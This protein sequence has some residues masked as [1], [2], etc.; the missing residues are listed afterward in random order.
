MAPDGSGGAARP[1]RRS[2]AA[3]QIPVDR[4]GVALSLLAA[5]DRRGA[6]AELVR[7]H[8]PR[9][10]E[11]LGALLRDEDVADD[12]YSIFCEWTLD[13]IGRYRG[14]ASLRTWAFG[15]AFNA[16]RRVRSDAYRRRKRTL[17]WRDVSEL[18][19][20]RAT[21][22]AARE[23][24]A[25][26]LDELRRHLSDEDQNLLALRVEQRLEWGEIVGVLASGGQAV[27]SAALR[28]R[29]ERL[30]DRIGKL[31]RELGVFE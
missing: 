1:A 5:G 31:A 23:R 17:R 2:L 15:V 16:A 24:A 29:F 12:A 13:A 7:V 25:R 8:G 20:R 10:R 6:A 9:V 27:S 22:S 21:S 3:Y 30:K 28:K 14:E 19:D 11:Y 18:P 26:R 4:D